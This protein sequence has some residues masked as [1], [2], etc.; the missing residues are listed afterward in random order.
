MVGSERNQ[1]AANLFTLLKK[2]FPKSTN[3]DKIA[4]ELAWSLKT[5]GKESE[6]LQEFEKLISIY[7][8]SPLASEAY[9]HLGEAAYTANDYQ[10]SEQHYTSATVNVT[11]AE[12]GEK[13]AHKLAWSQFQQKQFPKA[14]GSYASIKVA[15]SAMHRPHIEA[16]T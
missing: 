9:Y 12:V 2:E 14:L 16:L 8:K 1:D 15:I 5:T 11:D 13:A 10:K 7:P 6:A 3:G 4:Y